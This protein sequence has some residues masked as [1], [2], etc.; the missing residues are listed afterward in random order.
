[1]QFHLPDRVVDLGR[2][3][4]VGPTGTSPLTQLE[5]EVLRYLWARAGTPVQRD[6]LLV[7]VW[8][9]PKPV[10]TRCVDTAMRRIRAKIERDPRAPVHLQKVHGVGYRLVLE[11]VRPAAPLPG[12]HPVGQL[13]A[14]VTLVGRT[15][16][17][18][19][20]LDALERHDVVTL[21]GPPGVGRRALATA[22]GHEASARLEGGA[23]SGPRD[24]GTGA[25]WI[26]LDGAH[27]PSEARQLVLADAPLGVPGELPVVVPGLAPE[28]S[29]LLVKDLQPSVQQLRLAQAWGLPGC[30]KHGLVEAS[31]DGPAVVRALSAFPGS[32][33][34]ADAEDMG[35]QA[36][37]QHLLLTGWIQQVD[38][39]YVVAATRRVRPREADQQRHLAWFER[40]VQ[41]N[42]DGDLFEALR[43][44]WADAERAVD[45]ACA[46]PRG[47]PLLHR[48][49]HVLKAVASAEQNLRWTERALE[50]ASTDSDRCRGHT[51]AAEFLRLTG[52]LDEAHAHLDAAEALGVGDDLG[53][54]IAGRAAVLHT[55][56]RHA[57]ALPTYVRAADLLEATDPASASVLRSEAALQTL[58]QGDADEAVALARRAFRLARRAGDPRVAARVEGRLGLVLAR[59]GWHWEALPRLEA[60]VAYPRAHADSYALAFGLFHLA[61]S[62]MDAGDLAAAGDALT[63][64]AQVAAALRVPVLQA[65]YASGQ[66]VLHLLEGD[67]DRARAGLEMAIR[68]HHDAEQPHRTHYALGWLAVSYA[69][70]GLE[71]LAR[72]ALQ[73]CAAVSEH[74]GREPD[75]VV[76]WTALVELELTGDPA[77]AERV[78][79]SEEPAL[80]LDLRVLRAHLRSRVAACCNPVTS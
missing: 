63:E 44:R 2:R 25:L 76:A 53:Y 51:R 73:Q 31:A 62:R 45:T 29:A 52:L 27:Q 1:M 22:V 8:G 36:D 13:P 18:Q 40:W 48:L 23:C 21:L 64:G 47:I 50:A 41:A 56:L 35:L 12:G 66:G 58:R 71:R 34:A 9:Y 38:G 10:A 24:P 5:T 20:I 78:L 17:I 14:P 19:F 30:L 26:R 32:W 46:G 33:T 37:L 75:A 55:E 59:R 57:E 77:R 3:E 16:L 11:D 39:G 4:V 7:D 67:A 61:E 69:M 72:P 70:L 60:S 74:A 28:H 49:G 54:V 42:L 43:R 65:L 15:A 6:A 68:R 80:D 79:A